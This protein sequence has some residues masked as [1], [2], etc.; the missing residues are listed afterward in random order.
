MWT[1]KK[2]QDI[3]WQSATYARY[4]REAQM[5][6]S[7]HYLVQKSYTLSTVR[8]QGPGSFLP[9]AGTRLTQEDAHQLIPDAIY[10][11]HPPGL[12]QSCQQQ[13]S[14]KLSSAVPHCCLQA[15]LLKHQDLIS[16]KALK[17]THINYCQAMQWLWVC[18]NKLESPLKKHGHGTYMKSI[19]TELEKLRLYL[20][21]V[22][23]WGLGNLKQ[24]VLPIP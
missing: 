1:W 14:Y 7:P 13:K 9:L 24:L 2:K 16:W 17:S 12:L 21:T 3:L 19:V 18:P 10:T 22:T 8:S 20:A 11:M 6:I 4:L 23:S 5:N 15:M